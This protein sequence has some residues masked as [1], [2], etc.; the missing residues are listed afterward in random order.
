MCSED[1]LADHL[2]DQVGAGHVL[3]ESALRAPFEVDWTRRYTGSAR[4]VVRPADAAQV[5]AVLRVC[6]DAGVAVVPQGGNTGLVGGGVPAGGEV[7]LSLTR[8]DHLGDVDRQDQQVTAGAGVTLARLQAAAAAS[9]LAYGVDIAARDS[10]TVGGMIATNAGGIRVLRYGATRQQVI[11]IEAVTSD[12]RLLS[13]MSGL[14]KDNA[15]YDL[16]SLLTGSEGTLAV[17]TA[18]R[19]RLVARFR[20]RVVALVAVD[21][22]RGAQRVLGRVRANAPSLEAAE[23]VVAAGLDLVLRHTSASP[24]FPVPHPA[25]LLVEC[26]AHHDP[27][28]ELAAALEDLPEVRDVAVA[29]DG[30]GRARLWALREG[31]TEA[32]SAEGVPIKLDVSL[33]A[34]ALPQFAETV[35]DAVAAVAPDART[36]VFGHLG[37]GNLHVNV[38]GAP[39]GSDAVDDA[40]L[41]LA[42]AF[43]GS[44]SAEHGIGRAKLAWLPLYR[45]PVDLELTGSIKRAFD[46]RGLLNPGVLIPPA[47]DH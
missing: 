3:V 38:V 28:A 6:H 21:D 11:G 26:A 47:P 44:I 17:I 40:V 24:P 23:V 25:Y 43:G 14:V 42:I 4:L 30:P 37:D 31:H 12:G 8:L 19:L 41:R 22:I 34:D 39:P 5:A 10:A 36:I 2:A 16:A 32:I 7:V 1:R 45:G 29:T 18:A 27:T 20:R 9:D 13:R 35:H 33:P 15:G 46:P